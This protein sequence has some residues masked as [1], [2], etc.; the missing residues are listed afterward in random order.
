M[1]KKNKKKRKTSKNKYKKL[2]IIKIVGLVIIIL[3]ILGVVFR[4]IPNPNKLSNKNNFSEASQV[5]DRNGRLLYKFYADKNRVF[6]GID[7][8]SDNLK[9]AT[10]AIEDANFYKH[11]GFD[12]KGLLRGFYRTVFKQ[13]LQGGSTLTQQLVKNA[14]LSPERTIKRKIKEAIL[15]VAVEIMYSKDQILEMYFN[16]T[17]YGGTMWGVKAAASGIFNKDV[18]DLSLAEAA[19]IAGLPGSPSKYSPFTNPDG[20]KQR[21]KM[22]LAR[23]EELGMISKEEREKAEE[24]E[25]KYFVERSEIKA[26]HFVFE[27]REKL[28]EM[29]G[30]QTVL[31]GGLRVTTSLDLDLQSFAE[32]T[33]MSEMEKIEKYN[34]TNGAVLITEAK[35][36]Q[37]LAMVGSKNY[38]ADD[39]D[40]KYNVTTAL[41]QPGSSIKPIAYATGL[42]LGTITLA[43]VFDDR[44]TCFSVPNQKDYCPT[45]YGYSYFGVQSMRNALGNSLN[46]PA[47]KALKVTGVE[48][49]V[50]TASAMG[51]SSY[52]DADNYGLS[53]SLGG[54]E[55]KMV[56]MN[57]AFGVFANQ[58]V[59]QDLN[60][61]LKVEGK[62]NQELYK[63]EWIPGERAISRE[64]AFMIHS[65]LSDDGARSMVFGRGSLLNIK[66]HPE[67]AVK[68]GT[69][70]DLRDN[71]TIG[72]TPD[73]V[74]SVWVGNNNNTKMKGVVSGITGAA[75]IWNLVM[76][77]LLEEVPVK[78]LTQPEG[79][80]GI[81]VC[82]LTGMLPPE[83]GCAV[84]YEYFN[85]K[86]VPKER[87][88][89]ARNVLVDRDGGFLVDETSPNAEWRAQSVVEDVVG[90][91]VCLDCQPELTEDGKL[92]VKKIR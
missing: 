82:N 2:K 54:G 91:L 3:G 10:L 21:Q 20:A 41:R 46:I 9:K 66:G 32:E 83:E 79:I 81:N 89:L 71:W 57:T 33:V 84:R 80:V 30:L 63:Y 47:V 26:P 88:S 53:L 61:I 60:Y 50:A 42:E 40:G 69:T 6:V 52:V 28:V 8:V 24:E 7:Q 29:Y 74:V 13:R 48:A 68:T 23:M 35:T 25:L 92:K 73:Y 34:V 44:A 86:Y 64:T 65:V 59:R 38:W 22:V 87:R 16:Q 70:N 45:N 36:G 90:A 27:V 37:V 55:I 15:T 18:S 14:L 56:D 12:I 4:D 43:S 31:E 72:F 85:E 5:F 76:T 39:I 77:E 17:P 11:F 75:P 1:T 78:K 62:N 58:G 67:V 51:I 19:L 49:M